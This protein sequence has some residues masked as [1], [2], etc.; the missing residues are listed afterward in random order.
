L[1]DIMAE[2]PLGEDIPTALVMA[3]ARLILAR[4]EPDWS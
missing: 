1:R 2:A 4:L 3:G